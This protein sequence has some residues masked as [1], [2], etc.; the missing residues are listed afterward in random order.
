[1]SWHTL[2]T[3]LPVKD[4]LNPCSVGK[5]TLKVLMVISS[6]SPSISLY[7]SQYLY[8]YVFKVSP[9]R[10]DKDSGESKGR[11]TLLQV[12]KRESKAWVSSLKEF[13]ELALKPP[14][15]QKSQARGKHLAHQSFV[16]RVDNHPLVELAHIF[17]RIRSTIVNSECGLMESS[18]KFRPLYLTRE[19]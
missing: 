1:M 12:I 14:H 10:T 4:F 13:T 6:K 9:S 17:H 2:V 16:L 19:R 15:R 7:I 8:E 5:L 11:G 18:R 3:G